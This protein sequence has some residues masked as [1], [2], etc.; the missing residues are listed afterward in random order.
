ML[1]KIQKHVAWHLRRVRPDDREDLGC[2]AV[3]I[4]FAMFLR[5]AQQ[6]RI[7][8][9]Y[10]SPLAA[11]ACRQALAGRRVGGSMNINDV[12][13]EH[14]QRSKGVSVA[15]LDVLETLPGQWHELVV[16]D[17]RST[18]AD[19]AATRIDFG[20][21]LASLPQRSRQAAEV[22]ATGETTGAAASLLGVSAGRVSQLRR[23][24][25]SGWLTFQGEAVTATP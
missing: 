7:E 19:I 17:S 8:L 16:A 20:A 11:Y 23:E 15:Q 3:A 4:A 22:L 21:W 5:L 2:E 24:L 13:S 6:G 25:H 18:P 9:A 10:P 14:C 12:M 1:P